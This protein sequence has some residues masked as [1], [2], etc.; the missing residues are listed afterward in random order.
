MTQSLS[1]V[2][3]E[4]FTKYDKG[5]GSI[6]SGIIFQDSGGYSYYLW[7]NT[8]GELR[9]TDAATAEAAGFNWNTG[10]TKVGGQ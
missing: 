3:I 4:G 5:N 1:A 8:S 2:P 7:V 9:I 6:P 10:G